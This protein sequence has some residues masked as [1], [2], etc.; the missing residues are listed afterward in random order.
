[1]ASAPAA[2]AP[3]APVATKPA[4]NRQAAWGAALDA[5][6]PSYV[7]QFPPSRDQASRWKSGDEVWALDIMPMLAAPRLETKSRRRVEYGRMLPISGS[8]DW[9]RPGAFNGRPLCEESIE[10]ASP[11]TISEILSL[12]LN[13][14]VCDRATLIDTTPYESDEPMAL[15]APQEPV[16]RGG[17]ATQ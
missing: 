14:F 2:V 3:A 5:A 8:F 9:S 13:G 16:V 17:G 10:P 15:A 6:R 4:P 12:S 11:S 1:M 7:S